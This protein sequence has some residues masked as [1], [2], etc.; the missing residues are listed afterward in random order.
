MEEE[1]ASENRNRNPLTVKKWPL[2]NFHDRF[3]TWFKA[4]PGEGVKKCHVALAIYGP[5]G[6]RDHFEMLGRSGD[7]FT[8]RL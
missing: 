1:G 2:G 3:I 6:M 4:D 8:S 7:D 5:K